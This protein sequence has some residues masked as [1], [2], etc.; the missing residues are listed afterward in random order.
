MRVVVRGGDVLFEEGCFCC[1]FVFVD[2]PADQN[3]FRKLEGG[4]GR[5]LEVA[6]AMRVRDEA[7]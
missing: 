7:R 3:V 5:V 1:V 6:Q 2:T 4:G